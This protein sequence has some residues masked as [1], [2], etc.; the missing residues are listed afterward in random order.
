MKLYFVTGNKGKFEIAQD[1]FRTYGVEIEQADMDTP[2]IQSL[3]VGEIAVFSAAWAA[4]KLHGAVMTSDIGYYIPALGGFP[5]PFIKYINQTLCVED[6]LNLMCGKEN[7]EMIIREALCVYFPGGDKKIF[8]HE[9]KAVLAER[10]EG[11]GSSIDQIMILDGFDRP[12]GV[13]PHKELYDHWKRSLTLYHEAS[14]YLQ[15]LGK[16]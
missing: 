9:R 15:K 10:A 11:E 12:R 6:L 16:M 7:R 4:E 13:I 3:D 8:F 2:E 1:V 5:G 14:A